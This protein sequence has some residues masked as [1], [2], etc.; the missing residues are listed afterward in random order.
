MLSEGIEIQLVS[1]Q[2]SNALT[3]FFEYIHK[4]DCSRYF[5]PHPF[6]PE[7]AMKRTQYRGQDLY[8]VLVQQDYILGYGMLRGWDEGYDIP[9]LGI[10]LLPEARGQGLGRSFMH[11]LH[12][13]AKLKGATKI[14]LKV[15]G[16]NQAA[17]Q[18]Y[19]SLGYIFKEGED[20]EQ[21]VG[22]FTL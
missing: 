9:S 4:D 21:L 2:W 16:N 5:H 17:L 14:R 12:K 20:G 11:F 8:Y 18:L 19:K 6:T 15:Y 22:Y 7:E 1:E 3:N 10:C 13:A